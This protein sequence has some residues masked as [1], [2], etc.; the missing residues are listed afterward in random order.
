MNPF[1]PSLDR[2]DSSKG[3]EEGNVRIVCLMVNLAMN[4]WGHGPLEKVALALADKLKSGT[5]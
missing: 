1:A 2:I 4:T 5:R 3:Y